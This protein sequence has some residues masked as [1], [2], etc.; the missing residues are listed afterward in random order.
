MEYVY[1]DYYSEFMCIADKCENTCCSGWGIVIDR[2]TMK[3]YVNYNG[4]FRNRLLNSIDF[5]DSSFM[6]YDG[7]CAF[8]NEDNLCDIICETNSDMLCKT[9]RRYPRHYEEF[10]NIREISLSI[11]CPEAC[12]IILDN[13]NKVK[14]KREIKDMPEEMYEE[15]DFLLFTKLSDIRDLFFKIAYNRRYGI[16]QRMGILLAMGHDLDTRIRKGELFDIDTLLSRYEKER[17]INL[18]AARIK[19]VSGVINSNTDIEDIRIKRRE[20]NKLIKNLHRMEVLDRTFKKQMTE[21]ERILSDIS[22]KDYE[23]LYQKFLKYYKNGKYEY[24][25]IFVYFL[26]VYYLGA[27]YDEREYDK[28]V[29]AVSNTIIIREFDFAIWLKNNRLDFDMQVDFVHKFAREIE[30]SD[31]NLKYYEGLIK[32][33]KEYKLNNIL[34]GLF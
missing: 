5:D 10:E 6:Q 19:E 4:E 23:R 29:F 32:Y 11:S 21:Y 14:L 3:K 17:F 26:Y 30:H 24:E 9:C 27:V 12:R 20:K 25:Q 13:K 31:L 33:N 1:P 18:A 34:L 8:L 16:W 2:K 22:D 15:F 7:K 28:V